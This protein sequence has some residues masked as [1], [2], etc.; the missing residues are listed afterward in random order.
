[1]AV[2][3]AG[4]VLMGETNTSPKPEAVKGIKGG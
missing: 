1:L 3:A 4:D 2:C